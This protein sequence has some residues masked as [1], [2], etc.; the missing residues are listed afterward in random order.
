MIIDYI[1][2]SVF[3]SRTYIVSEK[4]SNNVW[5]VDCGDVEPL[6]KNISGRNV[7]GLFLTHTHFDHIYGLS[8]FM[9]QY[10]T[11]PIYTNE[12]GKCALADDRLNMSRYHGQPI[13]IKGNNVVI[14]HEGDKIGPFSI[15]ETPGHN[16]SCIC[17]QNKDCLFT[18][19]SYIP[20][21]TTVLNLPHC[22]KEQGHKSENRILEISSN[23]TIYPGH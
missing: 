9:K 15:I 23:K 10:P 11:V 22:N 6:L 5:V 7:L 12:Y 16:P 8:E 21:I 18:G 4:N 13:V 17:I 19:D 20:N 1:T 2:N 3:K 14:V